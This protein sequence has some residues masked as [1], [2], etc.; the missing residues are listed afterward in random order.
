MGG[1]KDL[2]PIKELLS[3]HEYFDNELFTQI[4]SRPAYPGD[5]KWAH[6]GRLSTIFLTEENTLMRSLAHDFP[7]IITI[8]SIGESYQKRPISLITLDARRHLV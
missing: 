4:L 3:Q 2:I 8:G 5:D 1:D 6:E 7:D